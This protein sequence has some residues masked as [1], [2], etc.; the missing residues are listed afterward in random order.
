MSVSD[1]NDG[2]S[3][4]QRENGSSASSYSGTDQEDFEDVTSKLPLEFD[5][6]P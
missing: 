2:N 5:D 6:G 3:D 4:S 1:K